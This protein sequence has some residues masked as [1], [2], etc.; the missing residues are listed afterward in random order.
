[1][2][3]DGQGGISSVRATFNI[4]GCV[5]LEQRGSGTYEVALNGIGRATV[6]VTTTDAV[7]TQACDPS[8]SLPL[9]QEAELVF[10]FAINR[11]VPNAAQVL[12]GIGLTFVSTDPSSINFAFG[13]QGVLRRQQR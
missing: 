5:I 12:D 9:P 2:R 6:T 7:D 8:N 13:T 3:A 10:E 4:G 11:V 1:M